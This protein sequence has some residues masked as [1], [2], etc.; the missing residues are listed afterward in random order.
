MKW[1]KYYWTTFHLTALGYPEH[2]TFQDKE[3]YWNF[4]TNFGKILPCEKCKKHYAEHIKELPVDSALE[5]RKE[6][7][8]WTVRF[9]NVVNV[10][11]G[12][13]ELTVDKSYK[14]YVSGAYAEQQLDAEQWM[15]LT[16][17]IILTGVISLLA[18]KYFH[19]KK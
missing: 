13:P 17:G 11:L 16:V 15:L 1:G 18:W 19:K 7:F 5:S 4:Y 12:K 3:L 14:H 9:H 8:A 2:P 10:S 6:L